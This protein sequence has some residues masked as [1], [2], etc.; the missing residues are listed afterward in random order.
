MNIANLLHRAPASTER[1]SEPPAQRGSKVFSVR[2][3]IL[4][5]VLCL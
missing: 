1:I 3:L 2:S 4:Q 5:G